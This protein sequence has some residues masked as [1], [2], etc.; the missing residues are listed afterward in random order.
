MKIVVRCTLIMLVVVATALG[1]APNPA[2]AQKVG[3]EA[4]PLT[5][6]T[7]RFHGFLP[8]YRVVE[9]LKAQGIAAKK[10]GK[11]VDEATAAMGPVTKKYPGYQAARVKAA[12]QV[13]YD[14]TK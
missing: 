10:A 2:F 14:E 3:T 1:L 5:I 11:T 6:A 13:I 7:G 9:D 4:K 8:A 12:M